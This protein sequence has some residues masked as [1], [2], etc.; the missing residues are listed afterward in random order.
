MLLTLLLVLAASGLFFAGGRI[1]EYRKTKTQKISCPELGNVLKILQEGH[2]A[3]TLLL[4]YG[5]NNNF[6]LMCANYKNGLVGAEEAI[7]S[8]AGTNYIKRQINFGDLHSEAVKILEEEQAA[9]E[10]RQM[11]L[12]ARRVELLGEADPLAERFKL[13]EE[14]GGGNPGDRAATK[15]ANAAIRLLNKQG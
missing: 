1:W 14:T 4:L 10:K 9:V 12:Q 2:G 13:L 6:S 7:Y 11:E 8:L 3:K 15:L 5:G